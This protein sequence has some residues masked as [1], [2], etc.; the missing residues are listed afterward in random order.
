MQESSMATHDLANS[1]NMKSDTKILSGIPFS[2]TFIIE[3][4]NE[5]FFIWHYARMNHQI[6]QTGNILLHVDE[7]ADMDIPILSDSLGKVAPDL[8]DAL[9]FTR[10]NIGIGE[11]I[12]PSVYQ[13]LFSKIYWMRRSQRIPPREKALNIASENGDG[14]QLIVTKNAFEAEL[15][16]PDHNKS[17]LFC[18]ITPQSIIDIPQSVILDIDLD[19]LFCDHENGGRHEM[20]IT[21]QEYRVFNANPYHRIRFYGGAIQAQERDGAYYYQFQKKSFVKTPEFDQAE[22]AR[23]MDQLISWLQRQ[24]IRPAL[25]TICRSRFSGFTP[26]EHWQW[27]EERLLE[28]LNEQF[29]ISVTYLSDLLEA[30]ALS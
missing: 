18:C 2:Q 6:P 23:H 28:K 30:N 20:Q 15:I 16:D 19:Y 22:I 11:F 25:I 26:S 10:N 8:R 24:N 9:R 17:A 21:E 12:I 5:A 7:H 27:M 13:G 14:Q 29:K 4:H 1:E 3:E